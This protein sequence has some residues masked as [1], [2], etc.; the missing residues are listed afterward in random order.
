MDKEFN[1]PNIKIVRFKD[2]IDVICKCFFDKKDYA[3]DLATPMMF[4]IS[5]KGH[6]LLQHW[7]PIAVMKQKH[8]RIKEEDI[9]CIYEPSSSFAEYY[10]TAVDKMNSVMESSKEEFGMEEVIQALEELEVKGVSIH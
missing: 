1:D 5:N 6:L 7:L 3:Y 8:V 9:L 2:G 4:D 10:S